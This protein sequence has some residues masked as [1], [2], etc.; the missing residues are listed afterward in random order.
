MGDVEI[1]MAVDRRDIEEVFDIRKVVFIE[2][3]NV[4]YDIEMDGLEDVSDHV[5]MIKGGRTI[6]CARIRRTGEGIKLER[7][8]VLEEFRGQGLGTRL[9]RFLVDRARAMDRNMI[10]LNSQ[11]SA[12]DFYARFGFKPEGEI[13]Q[14]ADI[15]HIRMVLDPGVPINIS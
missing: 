6:G 13:F 12:S 10:Y 7:V 14:E 8:A 2:G 1:K 15:D 11:C 9:M 5:I 4:P 3:Q